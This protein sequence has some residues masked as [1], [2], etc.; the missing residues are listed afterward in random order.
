HKPWVWDQKAGKYVTGPQREDRFAM[1][2]AMEGDYSSDWLSGNVFKADMW[3]WKSVRSNPL[4]LAHDK[5]TIISTS[6]LALP[7]VRVFDSNNGDKVYIA[8][9]SDAGDKLYK[10]KRYHKYDKD[11]MP[12]FRLAK[13]PP[14]GSAADVEVKGIWNDGK[15]CLEIRRKRDTGHVNDDV[16]FPSTGTVVGGIAIYDH[17]VDDDH[18]VSDNL[19]FQF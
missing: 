17:S 4:G 14:K 6:K 3:H 9:P 7:K 12:K 13:V 16:V 19:V 18:V 1:Q 10:I 2:F 11:V 5:H 8:R 15:W